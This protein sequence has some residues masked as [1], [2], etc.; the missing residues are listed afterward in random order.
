[1]DQ[2]SVLSVWP[3]DRPSRHD[4]FV[5]F[6]LRTSTGLSQ[7][8]V[9]KVQAAADSLHI[10]RFCPL[11]AACLAFGGK[12]IQYA[13]ALRLSTGCLKFFRAP[14]EATSGVGSWRQRTPPES[15]GRRQSV[16]APHRCGGCLAMVST[17][18]PTY[19]FSTLA[20]VSQQTLS[21]A[22]SYCISDRPEAQGVHHRFVVLTHEPTTTDPMWP[23]G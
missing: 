14:R 1:M 16:A 18:D 7:Y 3:F 12:E 8:P 10:L 22:V 11:R 13:L 20:P 2:Y 15:T 6:A 19:W 9:F 4:G 17:S 21:G 23:A 5:W